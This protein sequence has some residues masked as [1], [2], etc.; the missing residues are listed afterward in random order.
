M[1]GIA[2]SVTR[3]DK[4]MQPYIDAHTLS[5]PTWRYAYILWFVVVGTLVIWSL[6][7]HL[8][9]ASHGGT[10]WGAW[11]RKYSIRR[12]AIR[13]KTKRKDAEGGKSVVVGRKSVRWASPTFAQMAVVIALVAVALCLSFVGP[14]YI[15]VRQS[16]TD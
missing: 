4:V 14:D 3:A 6:A 2:F 10:A 13:G 9:G 12:I 11:F 1:F 7:Y 8:S 15:S 16:R 5:I